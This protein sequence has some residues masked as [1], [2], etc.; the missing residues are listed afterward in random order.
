MS[1]GGAALVCATV[2]LGAIGYRHLCA[3]PTWVDATYAAAMIATGMGPVADV[4]VTT[5]TAKLFVSAYAIFS[6]VV[7]L[8]FAAALLGPVAQRVI[9]RFHLD[10]VDDKP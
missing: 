1:V 3:A 9:H 5:P 4:P 7:F 8:T 6:G 10:Q 2:L